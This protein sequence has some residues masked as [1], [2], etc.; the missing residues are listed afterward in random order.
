[1]RKV[2]AP[3]LVPPFAFPELGQKSRGRQFFHLAAAGFDECRGIAGGPER[4]DFLFRFADALFERVDGKIR[5]LSVNHQWGGQ[6]DGIFSG[7]Q[8]QQAF[9]E[10]LL[11]NSVAKIPAAFLGPLIAHNFD[12]DH[13]T[14]AAHIADDFEFVRQSA[15]RWKM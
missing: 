11:H 4:L 15:V 14:L 8:N 1:M 10:S 2:G 9:V 12:A 6:T 5:L 13:Q 7:A 3:P